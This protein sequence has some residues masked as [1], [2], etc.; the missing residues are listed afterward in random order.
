MR[1]VWPSHLVSVSL[2]HLL[3][4]CG[5]QATPPV[6]LPGPSIRITSHADGQVIHGSRDVT[7]HG[8][9]EGTD[10]VAVSVIANGV[11]I[12]ATLVGTTFDSA[13][14]SAPVTLL[15][16]SNTIEAVFSAAGGGARSGP[17]HL[18]FPFVTLSTFQAAALVIGQVDF[19]SAYQTPPQAVTASTLNYTYGAVATDPS[20]RLFVP[21]S[22]NNRV[23]VFD[24]FPTGNGASADHVLGQVGFTTK[25]PGSGA[26]GLDMPNAVRVA[27]GKLFIADWNQ[28]RVL[29][30][31]SV[32]AVSGAAADVVLGW[33]DFATPRMGCSASMLHGAG[34][35]VV[36]DGKLLVAD[37]GNNRVLIWSTIPTVSGTPAD[38][39]LGQKNADH[40]A[41]N[42]ETGTGSDGA[43]PTARTLAV[44]TD[45]WSDGQRI[46]VSDQGNSRVLVWNSFPTSNLAPADLVLGQPDFTTH[47][48]PRSRS[49]LTT[50]SA[51]ASNG[52]QVAVADVSDNRVLVWNTF[53]TASFAA[54]DLVLGQGDFSH[55]APNDADQ[56][57][58]EDAAPAAT[59]L[60]MPMGVTFLDGLLV[61]TDSHNFR[62]LVYRSR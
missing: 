37:G 3:A 10:L 40:C 54:A 48:G 7:I 35:L 21:D 56:D 4:A 49:Q 60:R 6:Q 16:G 34:G 17:L 5:S 38:L 26:A 23:L 30:F 44:P 15:P 47:S 50:P 31:N 46:I 32:P 36:A 61:V 19:A 43:G 45:V 22:N 51:I 39:V 42:D 29:I 27:G 28:G 62:Y 18:V 14:F 11:T 13:G 2:A 9:L 52:N 59:T 53:P 20:G 24:A 33:S 57:G 8:T 25:F 12:A 55:A 41:W 1:R 58:I